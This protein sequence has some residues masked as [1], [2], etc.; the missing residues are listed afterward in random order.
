MVVHGCKV[1]RR[2]A[3]DR[4]Y[5]VETFVMTASLHQ[6]SSCAAKPCDPT[7]SNLYKGRRLFVPN[8]MLP[9]NRRFKRGQNVTLWLIRSYLKQ[10]GFPDL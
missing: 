7:I 2:A 5:P 8:P 1:W 3:F 9:G 6:E 4:P 10:Q